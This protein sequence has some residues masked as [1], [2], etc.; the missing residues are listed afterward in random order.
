[1]AVGFFE[2]FAALLP[3]SGPAGVVKKGEGNF[4]EVLDLGGPL[5]KCGKPL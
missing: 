2:R 3:A 5:Q 4:R 1:M